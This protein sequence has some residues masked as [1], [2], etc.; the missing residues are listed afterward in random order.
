MCSKLKFLFVWWFF[1]CI[2]LL[3][4]EPHK[5]WLRCAISTLLGKANEGSPDKATEPSVSCSQVN[6]DQNEVW[7]L[8][9]EGERAQLVLQALIPTQQLPCFSWGQTQG[10]CTEPGFTAG[11]GS[12]SNPENSPAQKAST[13][14]LSERKTNNSLFL[15]I[16]TIKIIFFHIHW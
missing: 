1:I 3:S 13:S 15:W 12:Q 2:D 9:L 6:W 7:Q 10:G 11:R 8:L 16:S 5:C 4:L 14:V